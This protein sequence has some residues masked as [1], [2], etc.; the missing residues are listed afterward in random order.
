MNH[1][2]AVPIAEA[3]SAVVERR[4]SPEE[5]ALV[6]RIEALRTRLEA[7]EEPITVVDHG[8]GRPDA[9]VDAET[10]YAGRLVEWRLGELCRTRSMPAPWP[11]LL[12]HLV[13]RLQSERCVE[14]GA[15]LGISS[16]YQAAALKLNRRGTLVTI[17]GSEALADIA[18]SNLTE[19]GLDQAEVVVGRFQE[20]LGDVLRQQ[21]PVDFVFID[22]HHDY[23]ATIQYFEQA[24][25]A[26]APNG[27][28]VFDD[29]HWS[30]GMAR[31]W[32]EI[33]RHPR[34]AFSIDLRKLGLSILG[35]GDALPAITVD[36]AS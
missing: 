21:E 20:R 3:L 4:F 9:E 2:L 25:D 19:L 7:V 16:A 10:A 28:V 27:V 22:G 6:A 30:R 18:R 32:D 36:V 31:A 24:L 8:V 17:E 34:A 11:L 12:F 14:L 23:R 35:H 13:R 33:Q 1:P 15:C 29:I 26:A 5:R